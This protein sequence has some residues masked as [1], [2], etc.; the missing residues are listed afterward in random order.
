MDPLHPGELTR[1][2]QRPAFDSRSGSPAAPETFQPSKLTIDQLRSLR[3]VWLS[4]ADTAD[5]S[6]VHVMVNRI[7][8]IIEAPVRL[9]SLD[10]SGERLDVEASGGP[11]KAV[12][13]R[14][15]SSWRLAASIATR[16]LSSS[17]WAKATCRGCGRACPLAGVGQI[18]A[19]CSYQAI[20]AVGHRS[21]GSSAWRG[22]CPAPCGSRV[23]AAGH[24]AASDC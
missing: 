15:R 12:A 2:D 1:E 11:E 16:R 6:P 10:R 3:E 8:E 13:A 5:V 17:P 4:V 18:R 22:I 7:A 19:C 14:E 21:T 23:I 9:V 20:G 24:A